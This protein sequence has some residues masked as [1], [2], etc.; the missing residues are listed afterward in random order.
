MPTE[1]LRRWGWLS[2]AGPGRSQHGRGAMKKG[3]TYIRGGSVSD[4]TRLLEKDSTRP[5]PRLALRLFMAGIVL[6]VAAFAVAT[7]RL[8]GG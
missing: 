5:G 1:L 2:A 8:L 3:R 4:M 6:A 7:V